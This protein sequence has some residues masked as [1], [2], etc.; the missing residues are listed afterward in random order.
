MNK[1]ILF[2]LTLLLFNLTYSQ[3]NIGVFTGVNYSY[4]TDGFGGKIYAE[5]SF[6]LQLGVLYELE[7]NSEYLGIGE[8]VDFFLLV[9]ST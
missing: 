9:L 7:I 4:L 8:S 6:G 1:I 5:N 2:S 3:K